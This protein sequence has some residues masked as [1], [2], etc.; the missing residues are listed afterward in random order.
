MLIDIEF[1]DEACFPKFLTSL[2]FIKSARRVLDTNITLSGELNC[3]HAI[4]FL[5]IAWVILGHT[6]LMVI[7]F[8]SKRIG[9]SSPFK[10]FLF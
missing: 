9:K 4:R 8:A 2:S 1:S 7:Y 10:Y 3:L 5:S 6:Y